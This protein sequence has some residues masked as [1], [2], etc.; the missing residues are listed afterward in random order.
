MIEPDEIQIFS[1]L[2]MVKVPEPPLAEVWNFA[3]LLIFGFISHSAG[4]LDF[5]MLRETRVW[6]VELRGAM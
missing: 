3:P 6:L 2:L 1:G 4:P 5:A